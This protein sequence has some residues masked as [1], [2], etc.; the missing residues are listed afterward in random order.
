MKKGG[1][2]NMNITINFFENYLIQ[3]I[4]AGIYEVS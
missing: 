2:K 1:G 4:V 3:V